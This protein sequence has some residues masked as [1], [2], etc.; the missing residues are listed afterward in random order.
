MEKYGKVALG[1]DFPVEDISTLKTFYA[2][3]IRKDS[4]GYP[5]NGFQT[6]NALSRK[7]ALQGMTIWAAYANF[8]EYEKG[9]LE[10]G[11]YAD[12]VI[13]DTDLLECKPGSILN[14]SVLSTF[15]NG[16]EVYTRK[17]E[18]STK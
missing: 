8:E 17:Q 1:T 14:A 9:S 6:E 7:E 3:T 5:E 10:A 18:K 2:A 13:M 12:L 11:K 15:I 4:E 16:E